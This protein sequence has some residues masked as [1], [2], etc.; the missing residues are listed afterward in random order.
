[1]SSRKSALATPVC[2]LFG[3]RYPVLSAGMAGG[4]AGP[5]LAAAV[6]D[7]GGLG[8]LGGISAEGPAHLR[9][10]IRRTRELTSRPFSVN[11]WAFLLD[12]VPGFFDVCIEEAVPSITLSF[13]DPDRF[14]GPAH[15]A[16]VLVLAQVQTVRGAQQAA[17]AGVDAIIAQGGEAGGHTGSVATMTLVPQAVD[18]AGHVPVIAAGGIADGR[19]LVAALALGAQGVVMGT[20]FVC[21]A[22]ADA[23]SAHR[24]RIIGANADDTIF[25][26]VFDVV[27]RL[28]WPAGISGRSIRTPFTDEWHGREDELR[29]RLDAIMAESPR[30]GEA[31]ERAHSFYAGQSAGLI[32]DVKPAAAIIA[33][34]ISEAEAVLTALAR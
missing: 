12:A 11:L 9:A 8:G 18:A 19:G 31:P 15:D 7:A 30:A 14:V 22:E 24:E 32:R 26:D 1:M 21:A 6:S 4:H 16:G 2:D 5:S 27:D 28:K 13:G 33:D 17:A 25:T 23:R 10:Q 29:A 34:I 20:R 3:V